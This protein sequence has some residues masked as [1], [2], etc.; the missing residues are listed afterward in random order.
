MERAIDAAGIQRGKGPVKGISQESLTKKVL[1]G[2]WDAT[3][4]AGE[5][6]SARA[7][8]ER[9]IK[10]INRQIIPKL[11]PEQT[12]WVAKHHTMIE[13]AAGLAGAAITTAEIV[14]AATILRAGLYKAKK[15]WEPIAVK[16]KYRKYNTVPR[17]PVGKAV[18]LS[19]VDRLVQRAYGEP[20][21]TTMTINYVTEAHEAMHGHN[22]Q[23]IRR[24]EE[25]MR[26]L[27]RS[28]SGIQGEGNRRFTNA[29]H[30]AL[31]KR[32]GEARDIIKNQFIAAYVDA[33]H[34]PFTTDR[35]RNGANLLRAG[36]AFRRW[37]DTQ[38]RGLEYIF[39]RAQGETNI[40]KTVLEKA[41]VKLGGRRIP[42]TI[43][44]LLSAYPSTL[45]VENVVDMS[46]N[47]PG[48]RPNAQGGID[49][50][51]LEKEL[52]AEEKLRRMQKRVKKERN[53]RHLWPREQIPES[54]RFIKVGDKFQQSP[55]P[56]P[57]LTLEQ[58]IDRAVDDSLRQFTAQRQ[59]KIDHIHEV[60][61][62]TPQR[63]HDAKQRVT[64]VA[65]RT[66]F[67]TPEQ[68][69]VKAAYKREQTHVRQ[70]SPQ[71][72]I[73]E[74]APMP[75][76]EPS[77]AQRMRVIK[78]S[79]NAETATEL[80]ARDKAYAERRAYKAAWEAKKQAISAAKITEAEHMLQN[81][82]AEGKR[83]EWMRL[84]HSIPSS[85]VAILSKA[86]H[87]IEQGSDETV[88]KLINELRNLSDK[89]TPE[90]VEK[91]KVALRLFRYI[92]DRS[93]EIKKELGTGQVLEGTLSARAGDWVAKHT[94]GLDILEK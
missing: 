48:M 44:E 12:Q 3:K 76:P 66:K 20:P 86:D 6:L 32:K 19:E 24:V 16:L 73:K 23:E 26:N 85:T 78:S 60:V 72:V 47:P 41:A 74:V 69:S 42:L 89:T 88:G 11:S 82:A 46:M 58:T 62:S 59:G 68:M 21:T 77:L 53:K 34:Q 94:P 64:E 80:L 83:R 31:G 35:S 67:G 70:Q 10:V 79:P 27:I 63:I 29:A 57:T 33:L 18:P 56:K 1:V 9:I 92:V 8:N 2:A 7:W 14:A 43:R 49:F 50:D 75:T 93:P 45:P 25:T 51:Y 37:E 38:F 61:R 5:G 54:T 28:A 17:M 13:K 15:M 30:F 36:E 39:Q 81:I 90:R 65:D 4:K 22:M 52:S 91:S 71:I 55:P 84:T 40:D 87:L